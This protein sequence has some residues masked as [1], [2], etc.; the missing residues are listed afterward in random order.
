MVFWWLCWHKTISMKTTWQKQYSQFPYVHDLGKPWW[1]VAYVSCVTNLRALYA[2]V[3]QWHVTGMLSLADH[4]HCQ[5]ALSNH[6]C[7][8]AVKSMWCMVCLQHLAR[9]YSEQSR[10]TSFSYIV[11]QSGYSTITLHKAWTLDIVIWLMV[12]CII[13]LNFRFIYEILQESYCG[14]VIPHIWSDHKMDKDSATCC[15]FK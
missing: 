4:W 13:P 3:I 5:R 8:H 15:Y 2:W 9:A 14:N 11:E 10:S 7:A 6:V 1:G 12:Q